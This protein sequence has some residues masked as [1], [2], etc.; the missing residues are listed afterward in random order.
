VTDHLVSR[1]A[2]HCE[3]H[4]L[5][6]DGPLLTMVSGGADSMCL[7]HMLV[8]LHRHEV[9]VLTI[10]HGLRPE[11][12]AEVDGVVHT[13][14]AL[15]CAIHVVRLTLGPG[16]GV[17][18][19]ARNAR[20]A[21][22]RGLVD[23]AGYAAVATGHTASDQAE[24]VLFRLARGTG[25]TGA[26]AMA[27]RT[28]DLV[29]PLLVVTRD[30]IREWCRE[31][32]ISF[33]DD[34]SNADTAYARAR[35][36]HD[37]LPALAAVHPGAELHLAAFADRMQDE[38]ALLDEIV[39]AAWGRCFDGE[40]LGV[41]ALLVEPP[42]LRALL[43]RRLIDAAGLPGDAQAARSV[44]RV[45]DA[46]SS[47]RP[48]EIPGGIALVERGRLVVERPPI[49]APDAQPLGVP[50]EVMFGASR[51]SA[52]PGVARDPRPGCVAVADSGPLVVRSPRAGDRIA[53]SGGGSQAVG[54]LL[55]AAGVPSRRR[56]Q[57][58][59][60]ARGNDVVWVAGH[61][62]DLRHL[63]PPGTPATI[64]TLENV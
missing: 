21:V 42:P 4:G 31:N 36:R 29:R 28:G 11:A 41:V 53:L 57:V 1:V 61:R 13:A 24:T 47:G 60:V 30:E 14:E 48:I 5:L 8:A 17:Q 9:G 10:D 44:Q 7:L 22:A 19:R 51:V 63:A 55:A 38:A 35:V 45:V 27:P 3:R 49:P 34:P 15:G 58:P 23:S 59:L 12:A 54:R 32:R 16:N 37:L 52:Q 40:G 56:P 43:V 25:R 6:P 2:D 26:R 18:V 39:D 33:V 20:R 46:A 50:G 62:A 64:L